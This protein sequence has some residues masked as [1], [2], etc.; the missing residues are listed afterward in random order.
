MP[1]P[2]PIDTT[3]TTPEFDIVIIGSGPA[4]LSAAGRASALGC[5]HVL[6]E[7][8]AHACHTIY[9]YQKG[10]HVMA[11]PSVLPLRS[12]LG[13]AAGQREAL[14]DNWDRQLGDLAVNIRYGKRVKSIVRDDAS[15]IF[16][17]G[18]E[19]GS[20]CTGG[21]V[22][23]AIGMQ[24]NVR[25]LGTPGED[26][27][28]VQYTLADPAQFSGETIVVV[29][30]GDAGIENALALAPHNTVILFNRGEEFATCKEGNRTLVLEAEKAGRITI[31][32]CAST[33]RVDPVG[34]AMPLLM[35]YNGRTG[36][37][38]IACHRVIARLGATPPRKLIESFGVVFPN[39]NPNAVPVL[40]QSYESNVR[41]LYIVGALGGYPLIKQAMNQGYEVVQSILGKPVQPVDEGLLEQKFKL[42]KPGVPVSQAIDTILARIPLFSGMSR[43]QFREFMLD[44]TLLR[45][46]PHAVIFNRLDYTDTFYC[47]IEG[48]VAVDVPDGDGKTR[49]VRIGAGKYFGEMALISG[50]RRSATVRAGKGCVLLETP[51]HPMLKLIS[52]V[53]DVARRI[54]EVFVRHAVQDY[55]GAKLDGTAIDAL[56]A[57][58]ITARRYKAGEVIF[59]EGDEADGL[60]L[61]RSG[62]VVVSRTSGGEECILSYVAAGNYVGEMALVNNAPRSANI[63]AAVMTEVLVL[64]AQGFKQQLAAN[65]GWRKSIETQVITRT[66]DDVIVEQST[67]RETDLFRFLLGHGAGEASDMLLINESMCI[68]CN[69]C[70]VACAETH[71]GTSRLRRE[72]GPTF[73]NIH[74]PSACRHCEHPHC[75]KDCPP[76][77]ISRSE[78]GEVVIS[79]ACIGCGNCERN[80]PYGEIQMVVQKKPKWGGGLSWLM[81]GLGAAPGK[82]QPDYDPNAL[83]KAVKCDL[84]RGQEGGAA[85]VRACPTGAAMRVAPEDFFKTA[86]RR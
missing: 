19:D 11:E 50:R 22:I 41:G 25:K 63:T 23:L 43:L 49:V 70:E 6:L 73:A 46:K 17:I 82:R 54:D 33:V 12:D 16:T 79:D 2:T 40:S 66:Q 20:V 55:V 52:L 44:S 84:C 18:C 48:E 36:E 83:K 80:C 30:S 58:G 10:K 7:A 53:E 37:G 61:I 27:E 21:A 64:S 32:F 5:R 57:A 31:C 45:P 3:V 1:P 15:G 62:S 81:F 68:Q 14:L 42:W 60:Y 4:G 24:G 9:Q 47:I 75:M 72:S 76:D 74:I 39:A 65:P 59:R 77:A 71:D 26:H 34:A 29:G 38:T 67:T 78:H 35:V 56:I 69:N 8:Q 51:R 86:S 85:C 28:R 13:F